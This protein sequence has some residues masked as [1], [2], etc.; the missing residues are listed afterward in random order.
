MFVAL[1]LKKR[2]TLAAAQL[3]LLS[4]LYVP[5][6]PTLGATLQRANW[7]G[8]PR[9][10]EGGSFISDQIT[11]LAYLFVSFSFGET[12]STPSL[13]L[14][15]ALTPFVIYA[16]WRGLGSRPA[17]ATIVLAAAGIAWLGVSRFEQFVFMPSHLLFV[18]P[19]FLMLILRQI[20]PLAFAALLVLYVIADY[21]YF[22]R[23][24]FL[25]KP[26]AAPYKEMAEVI[27]DRSR[28]QN[29]ILAVSPYGAFF[30][31]LLNRLGD[32]IRVI[33]LNNR[34]SAR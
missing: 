2:V 15:V 34:A 27:R 20:A 22:T 24:D 23:G 13:L 16:L 14:S 32:S 8:V 19:F 7:I 11:R 29:V 18:L 31:P 9:P 3:T 26:Y 30:Q 4:I 6:L 33:I 28:G 21:A 12:I 10:Y 17:W 1:L 25:V 5:W